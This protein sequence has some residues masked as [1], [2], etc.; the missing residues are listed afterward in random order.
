[1][2]RPR[3]RYFD[4]AV[5][6]WPSDSSKEELKTLLFVF[7]LLPAAY[8]MQYPGQYPPGSYPPGQ[9]PP[10]Q[11]P[12]GT[13]PPG[14]GTGI[15]FPR[16]SKSKNTSSD[17]NK[18]ADTQTISGIVRAV[19]PKSIDVEAPDTRVIT[20]KIAD[21]TKKPDGLVP[22]D[23]VDV[24]ATQ[25]DKGLF[26][27]VSIKKTG[28][29][30]PQ[31]ADAAQADEPLD[32]RPTTRLATPVPLDPDD[33]GGPPK[34]KRGVPQARKS[35]SAPS[36]TAENRQLSAPIPQPAASQ[37][38]A[39]ASPP[40]APPPPAPPAATDRLVMIAKAREAAASFLSGLPNYVCQQFTTRYVSVGHVTNWQ[41]QDIVSA[42]VVYEDGK[43]RYQNLAINGK[44]AK[45][46]IEETG[47]WSTGEFG[48]VLDDLFSPATAAKFKF[49][50]NRTIARQAAVLFD[51]DVDHP[52]S[53]WRIT[54][55]GQSIQ[56]AYH[57]SVWISKETARV[58]RI[59]MQAVKIPE[60]FPDD[61]TE[62]ALDYDFVT[63]GGADKFLLPTKAEILSCQR[64]TNS[65]GRN[66]IEFRNYHR[67]TGES[68]IVFH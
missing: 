62:M 39:A 56:P 7:V 11:Y 66:T 27:A 50:G 63:L 26:H 6:K 12:P 40:A 31:T 68:T 49:V 35:P 24:E 28:S 21:T 30:P 18:T 64:G 22:G 65:C 34:L 51:F 45:Q 25:D 10:G 61:T 1:M 47:A 13:Y 16:K 3:A 60:A 59:E 29:A 55:S 54:V 20:F 58:L 23:K 32:P 8:C 44:P 52:H 14:Q 15:P 53:H 48:T 67:Y 19:D 2:T 41:A 9:Y 46:A 57:G 17:Q 33:E 43:E 4:P 36:E 5:S 37:A 38:P 42:E